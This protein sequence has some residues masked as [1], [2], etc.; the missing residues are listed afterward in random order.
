MVPAVVLLAALGACGSLPRTAAVQGEILRDA[1]REGRDIAVVPVTRAGLATLAA[2]PAPAPAHDWLPRSAGP[3]TPLIRPGDQLVLTVWDNN[4]NSLLTGDGQRQVQIDGLPVSPQGTVFVPYLDEIAVGGQTPDQARRRI[5]EQLDAILPSAQ[6]QLALAGGRRS[7]VDLL[8]GV[9]SP[10]SFP[11]PDRNFTV[12]NLLSAGGGVAPGLRNP[13]LRLVR[14]GRVYRIALERV[15]EDPRLDTVLRGGD[16]LSVEEDRR[17]FIALGAAGQQS[18]IPFERDRVSA[19]DAVSMI[20]GVEGSRG[21][22]GGVLVLREYPEGAVRADGVGGPD[23]ARVVFTV[24]LTSADGLFSARH[25]E[26]APDDLVLVT[27]APVTSLRT[28]LLLLGQ[29][30]GVANRL[31]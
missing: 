19:L 28:V 12:L 5:Q 8:G 15:V 23:R 21:A 17:N 4:P 3:E 11:L 13:Q 31:Q 26:I 9:G 25:F 16:T 10:G 30:L 27:E 7:S 14:D 6:V 18:L 2:W 1:G 20:G 29:T 22:P 24:D